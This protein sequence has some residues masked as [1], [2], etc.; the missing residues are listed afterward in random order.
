MSDTRVFNESSGVDEFL[1]LT[2]AERASITSLQ[3]HRPIR[4]L[5]N[6]IGLSFLFGWPT[7]TDRFF[8]A[9][10]ECTQ[11][12]S[13]TLL[14]DCFMPE[15]GAYENSPNLP[16]GEMQPTHIHHS[17]PSVFYRLRQSLRQLPLL[18]KLYLKG[19]CID[20][21]HR[22]D[23]RKGNEVLSTISTLCVS[24][25]DMRFST[26]EKLD[27]LA[28]LFPNVS[29]FSISR[30]DREEP[31]L[32]EGVD[33]FGQDVEQLSSQIAYF[34]LR[35]GTGVKLGGM[36]ALYQATN[37]SIVRPSKA[38][39]NVDTLVLSPE[40]ALLIASYLDDPIERGLA[41]CLGYDNL[42]LC[43][44]SHLIKR[45]DLAPNN[46]S[47][48]S[49]AGIVQAPTQSTLRITKADAAGIKALHD[50]KALIQ[51]LTIFLGRVPEEI[52]LGQLMAHLE[53]NINP[54]HWLEL[55]RTLDGH[56][57]FTND[58]VT[59]LKEKL[60][61]T[62]DGLEAALNQ[63]LLKIQHEIKRFD[64]SDERTHALISISKAVVR[65]NNAI[66][67][68]PPKAPAVGWCV[69]S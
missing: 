19:M 41:K 29:E 46:N 40:V 51:E 34:R 32:P 61:D 9:L 60:D 38:R 48:F 59:H 16:L 43:N 35:V 18:T 3:L 15:V 56:D 58:T 47:F 36:N 33:P 44:I 62:Y 55:Q 67:P 69:P 49:A 66:V 14:D 1:R 52:N 63:I 54:K 31:I 28:G 21:L 37:K 2:L 53:L 68:T 10:I 11:L 39:T 17:G 65:I 42:M 22:Q 26:L 45:L 5:N 27:S 6:A 12:T 23:I 30:G 57:E 7:I 8:E 13:L 64:S 24:E 4:Q 50:R 25:S 20:K